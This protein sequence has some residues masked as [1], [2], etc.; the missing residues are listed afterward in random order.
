MIFARAHNLA[1]VPRQCGAIERYQPQTSFSARDQE[2]R[3]V[4]TKPRSVV[5]PSD[6]ND[7][8]IAAQPQTG[9]DEPMRRVFVS[10]EP[11]LYRSL[12]HAMCGFLRGTPWRRPMPV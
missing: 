7:R 6:V 12:R 8:T 2:R 1:R 9:G 4:Q 3:I 5:P 11:T 10:E